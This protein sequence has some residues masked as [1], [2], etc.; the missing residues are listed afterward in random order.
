MKAW[1]QSFFSSQVPPVAPPQTWQ[2]TETQLPMSSLSAPALQ[3]RRGLLDGAFLAWM[4][5]GDLDSAAALGEQ[6]Q[7]VLQRLTARVADPATHASLLPRAAGVVPALLARLRSDSSS[8]GELA[9]HVSRDPTLVA[10]VVAMANSAFYRRERPVME[11]SHSIQMLGV[12]GLRAAI[13]RVVLKPMVDARSGP[14]IKRSAPRL[15][16]HTEFK[17]QLGAEI[18]RSQG[19]DPFDAYMLA[20]LHDIAWSS[21]LRELDG[22][23]P[24][25]RLSAEFVSGLGQWR[26]RLAWLIAQQ[27]RPHGPWVQAAEELAQQGLSDE[28]SPEVLNLCTADQLAWL[29]CDPDRSRARALADPLLDAALPPVRACFDDLDPANAV[30]E[31]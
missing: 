1:F 28:S 17:T 12:G 22:A 4:T 24:S 29:L 13:A 27:W 20:L 25:W 6:E 2:P 23:S 8:L 21:V 16:K 26:D 9:E 15:W 10:E 18:A 19:L 3:H 7:R 11:L 31:P 5:Q 30:R 14:V